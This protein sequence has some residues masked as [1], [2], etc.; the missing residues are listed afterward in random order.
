MST[1]CVCL[2]PSLWLMPILGP[3]IMSSPIPTSIQPSSVSQLCP[4]LC[5]PMDHSLPGSSVLE[6]LQ[7]RV[8]EWVA[9]S[10]S[11][12]SSWPTDQTCV[13]C[14]LCIGSFIL[15]CWATWDSHITSLL[16]AFPAPHQHYPIFYFFIPQ[17]TVLNHRFGPISLPIHTL[18]P[19]SIVY[20]IN[21]ELPALHNLAQLIF[22]SVSSPTPSF[23]PY[24][25]LAL[26]TLRFL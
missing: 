22:S 19:N 26:A 2:P 4:A 13:S 12:R 18:P 24:V 17:M 11:G 20:R 8:L 25:L 3:L 9:I 15:H 1:L 10:S 14:V 7:A 6:I 23:Q 21:P 16:P 5:D